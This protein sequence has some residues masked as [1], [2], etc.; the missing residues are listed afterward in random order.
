VGEDETSVTTA[1]VTQ[2]LRSGEDQADLAGVS[3]L[4]LVYDQLRSL[5]RAR[6][7][8]LAPGQTI[9]ATDLVHEAWLRIAGIDD[10]GWKSRGHFFGAAARAMR[11]I[12]VEQARRKASLKRDSKRKQPLAD[13]EPM[14]V[15]GVPPEDVIAVHEALE[16]FEESHERAA[17]VVSLRFFGGL[18]MPELADV[19]EISLA[20]AEREWR[21]ARAWLQTEIGLEED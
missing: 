3:L 19:M 21:F 16:Q 20:T 14:I 6:V 11:N 1:R 7:A 18:T 2:A 13:E 10:P 4:P 12:L 5:A 8:R 9:Q 15:A 17:R